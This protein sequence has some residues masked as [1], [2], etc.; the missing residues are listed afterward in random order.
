MAIVYKITNTVNGKIYIGY[1]KRTLEWRWAHHC[2]ESKRSTHRSKNS[3]FMCAIRKYGVAAFVR[4][5]LIEDEAAEKCLNYWEPFFIAKFNST[6]RAVGY[7]NTSGGGAMFTYTPEVLAKISA[8]SKACWADPEARAK[9]IAAR[10]TPEHVA[11]Q[12]VARA[13]PEHVAKMRAAQ[14]AA[15]ANPEIKAKRTAASKAYWETYW[16]DHEVKAKRTAVHTTP[17]YIAKQSAAMKAY[18]ARPEVKAKQ[19][20]AAKAYWETAWADPEY[21][22]RQRAILKAIAA[23]AEVKAKKR[24]AMKAY[25]ARPEVKAKRSAV[26]KERWRKQKEQNNVNSAT[27]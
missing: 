9:R 3:R 26:M 23:K 15:N 21:A 10:A 27:T 16:A 25:C 5:I 8:A 24:A 14:K 18:R 4:E 6:D 17:E 20:A 13:T 12:K 2:Y 11:K 19:S 7:N 1:T 22:D